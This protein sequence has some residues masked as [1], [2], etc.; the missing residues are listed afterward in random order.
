M[1]VKSIRWGQ[2]F[3][4][5]VVIETF[6]DLFLS[7]DLLNERSLLPTQTRPLSQDTSLGQVKYNVHHLSSL[8]E[9]GHLMRSPSFVTS[10]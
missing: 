3:H 2:S 4:S 7:I 5:E 9:T 1:W 6:H 8:A 10:R